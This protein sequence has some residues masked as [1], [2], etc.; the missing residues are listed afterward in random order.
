MGSGCT[1]KGSIAV[2]PTVVTTVED[3]V[4]TNQ[5]P[6]YT[7]F[8]IIPDTATKTLIE[9][10][11]L[12]KT[13]STEAENDADGVFNHSIDCF[14]V[15]ADASRIF[16]A[17]KKTAEAKNTIN[18]WDVATGTCVSTM[19]REGHADCVQSICTSSDGSRCFSGSSDNTIKVWDVATG[20]CLQ[21]LEGHAKSVYSVCVS[22]DGSRCFSG[23]SNGVIK[24]WDVTTGTCVQTLEGHEEE[25]ITSLCMSAGG[26]LFSGSGDHTIKEWDLDT[27]TCVQTMEAC[28]YPCEPHSTSGHT[29]DVTSVCL[30]VDGRCFSGSSD[31]TIKVWD[32]ATGA[33]VQTLEGCARPVFS[34]YVTEDGST[35]FSGSG[36]NTIKVW[37]VATGACMQTLEGNG[38]SACDVMC[39][40]AD[41]SKLF[42][43]TDEKTITIWSII[44]TSRHSNGVIKLKNGS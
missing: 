32:V 1:K 36:D 13:I 17:G 11:K 14:C 6:E 9:V 2:D 23:D 15:L 10:L 39:V 43:Q 16:T 18:V 19:Y 44:E 12:D 37:N 35:C 22:L 33:C 5:I 7:G 21:T 40:S 31:N 4:T 29:N 26:R 30:S 38:N 34:V 28:E 20:D 3:V 27:S 25:A 41:R 8:T 42:S 24:V